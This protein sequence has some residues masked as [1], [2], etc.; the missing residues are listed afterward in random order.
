MNK[1]AAESGTVAFGLPV[2]R[3]HALTRAGAGLAGIGLGAASGRPSRLLAQEASP[4]A[5]EPALTK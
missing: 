1:P 3:R 4:P 5:D 2:T